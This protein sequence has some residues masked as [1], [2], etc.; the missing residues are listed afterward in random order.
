M[1]VDDLAVVDLDLRVREVEALR[2]VDAS[3]IPT[4]PSGNCHAAVLA[5]AEKA[6]DLIKSAH[7]LESKTAVA[8]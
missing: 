1:G 8:V 3:V 6:A 7:G 4:V 5:I 2:V